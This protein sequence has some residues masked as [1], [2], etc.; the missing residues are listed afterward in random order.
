MTVAEWVSEAPDLELVPATEKL[1]DWL[2]KAPPEDADRVLRGLARLA[3]GGAGACPDAALVLAWVMMP[4]ATVLAHQL[5][6]LS[7]DIDCH[8]AAQLWS[9]VRTFPWRTTGPVAANLNRNL[10]KKVLQDLVPT[11]SPIPPTATMSSRTTRYRTRS[12][13]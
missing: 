13:N 11:S 10:R 4:S 8:V 3:H 12:R 9:A 5:R 6:T 1:Y 7:E 2:R